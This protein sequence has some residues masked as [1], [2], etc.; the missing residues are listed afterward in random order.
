[1]PHQR[2]IQVPATLGNQAFLER[3]AKP[4]MI[5]LVGG[6]SLIDRAITVAERYVDEHHRPSRW[7][8]A[9]LCGERRTDGHLWVIESDLAIHRRHIRLGV[10]ENRLSKF[11]CEESYSCLGL[12]DLNLSESQVKQ[13]LGEAL[14]MVAGRTRYSL[15]ELVGTLLVL[16]RDSR[17]GRDN[18]LAR[19]R[20]IYCSA[21]VQHLFRKV[22]I[23]LAPGLADKHTTPED[24][25]RIP[26]PHTLHVLER[27]RARSKI[28]KLAR[29]LKARVRLRRRKSKDG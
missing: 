23:D 8:H 15:R 17:V 27:E 21:L 3:F 11:Y 9:F 7:S 18:K 13:L 1:M 5:G 4:G 26:L 24:L 2:L 10:Q 29:R 28:L 22:G 6:T 25:S 20:S 19:E 12:V 14:E 16:P